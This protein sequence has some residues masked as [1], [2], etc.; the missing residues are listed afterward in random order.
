MKTDS[1]IHYT[2]K[3]TGYYHLKP[4]TIR[5]GRFPVNAG[6]VS[7][8]A[9]SLRVSLSADVTREAHAQMNAL[10]VAPQQRRINEVPATSCALREQDPTSVVGLPIW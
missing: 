4:I 1:S 6:L 3:C 7:R 5:M 9:I 8:D 10:H 2:A